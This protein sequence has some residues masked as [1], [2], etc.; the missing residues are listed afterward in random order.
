[1]IKVFCLVCVFYEFLFYFSIG[2]LMN[3]QTDIF[4]T[5]ESVFILMRSY[6]KKS[7]AFLNGFG[8]FLFFYL[9]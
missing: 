7:K 2:K 1:M 5:D 8:S 9:R 3:E 6:V 4:Q